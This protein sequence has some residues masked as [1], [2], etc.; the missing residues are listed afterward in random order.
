MYIGLQ[1]N[2]TGGSSSGSSALRLQMRQRAEGYVV[3][4]LRNI[5]L[6]RRGEALRRWANAQ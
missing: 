2:M 6:A 1:T 3:H 5:D 4:H